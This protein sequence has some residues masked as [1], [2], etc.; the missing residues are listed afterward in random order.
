MMIQGKY[1]FAQIVQFLPKRY[2]ERLVIKY[3]DRIDEHRSMLFYYKFAY[4]YFAQGNYTAALDILDE[5]LQTRSSFLREDIHYNA[6]LLEL[7]CRYQLDQFML[8]D[9][10]LTALQRLLKKGRDVSKLQRLGVSLLRKA[11]GKPASERRDVFR[12]YLPELQQLR[13]DPYE[14]KALKY[15]DL[16]LWVSSLLADQTLQQTA[17][18]MKPFKD[19]RL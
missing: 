6:H 10:R 7:I 14:R 15:L 11:I 2:F 18:A 9:Y 5:I 12:Y 13:D 8:L 16:P 1:V 17:Q 19:Q 4:I 3:K